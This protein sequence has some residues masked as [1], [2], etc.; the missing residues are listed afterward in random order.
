MEFHEILY[1]RNDKYLYSKYMCE[2]YNDKIQN[3][4][5]KLK[6]LNNAYLSTKNEDRKIA[7]LKGIN[8]IEKDLKYEMKDY[9]C[10]IFT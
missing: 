7:L 9:N 6:D 4:K 2:Y 8:R 10:Y 3:L 5:H 1:Y